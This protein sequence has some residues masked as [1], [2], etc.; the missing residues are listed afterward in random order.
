MSFNLNT[1]YYINTKNNSELNISFEREKKFTVN[2]PFF[3]TF[4]LK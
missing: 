4:Q 2:G 3:S 1:A